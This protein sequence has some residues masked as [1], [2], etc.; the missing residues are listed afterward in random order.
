MDCPG[1]I[2][3][4]SVAVGSMGR[5]A[6]GGT[7]RGAAKFD[8]NFKI[9]GRSKYFE[10]GKKGRQKFLA[11][12]CKKF[13]KGAAN[14]RSVPGGRHPSYATDFRNPISDGIVYPQA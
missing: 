2:S 14:L 3:G 4:S 10:A 5:A 8:L 9:W 13:S 11:E 12:T 7:F 6:A 1:R